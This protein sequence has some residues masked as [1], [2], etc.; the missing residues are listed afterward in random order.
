MTTSTLARV[1][2][3]LALT[4][5]AG[6]SRSQPPD[7]IA[8]CEHLVLAQ[9]EAARNPARAF[10]LDLRARDG[11]RLVYFGISSH[12]FDPAD[13]EFADMTASWRALQPTEAFYEGSGTFVGASPE[14]GIKRSGEPGLLR[15]LASVAHVPAHSLEP[16]RQAEVEAL[17]KTFTPEQIV[18]FYVARTASEARDR[19]HPSAAEL[20]TFLEQQLAQLHKV[21]QLTDT[22]PD[23]AAVRAAYGRWFPGKDLAGAPEQWFDP[24]KTSAETGSRFFNDVNRE[25]SLFRDVFMYRLLAGAAKPGARVF[26]EVGRDHIPAQAA[27]LKCA[28]QAD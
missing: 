1:A 17:L 14:A 6:A 13:P 10:A 23:L 16:P 24:R 15:Y 7:R 9:G 19:M 5:A 22:L 21:P 11:A 8:A 25:S 28:L 3:A 2:L 12:T 27:A 26:A 4:A 18:L 20:E